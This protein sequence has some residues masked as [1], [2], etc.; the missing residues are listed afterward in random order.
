[1]NDLHTTPRALPDA[2]MNR[3]LGAIAQSEVCILGDAGASNQTVLL[4]DGSWGAYASRVWCSASRRTRI[5][6]GETP[7]TARGDA[8]APQDHARNSDVVLVTGPH[9]RGGPALGTAPL[10]QRKACFK[11]VNPARAYP[12]D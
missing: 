8:C 2:D 12:K 1:M 10:Q 4:M 9:D 6:S 5:F 11:G 3:A 7:E